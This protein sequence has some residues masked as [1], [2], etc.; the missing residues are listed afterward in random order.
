MDVYILSEFIED[1]DSDHDLFEAYEFVEAV[2]TSYAALSQYVAKNYTQTDSSVS[3]MTAI[4]VG[5]DFYILGRFLCN[6][7]D[8]EVNLKYSVYPVI[9]EH[10]VKTDKIVFK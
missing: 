4:E 9:G 6:R 2:F 10:S 5:S 8:E 1:Y 3:D 7:S